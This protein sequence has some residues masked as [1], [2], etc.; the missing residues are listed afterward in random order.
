MPKRRS[1]LCTLDL[2][3]RDAQV[4]ILVAFA[5]RTTRVERGF[6][7]AKKAAKMAAVQKND[8]KQSSERDVRFHLRTS[9]AHGARYWERGLLARI[10]SLG[11][12][13]LDILCGVMPLAT[14]SSPQ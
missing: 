11:S 4:L 8:A 14:P 13:G 9:R 7:D 2:V 1:F 5:M 3:A 12:A 10:E 6:Q